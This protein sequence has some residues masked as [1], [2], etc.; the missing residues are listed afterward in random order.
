MPTAKRPRRAK[1]STPPTPR[2]CFPELSSRAY[3]HPADRAALA[4]LRKVK[5]VDLV[6]R[7]L[8]GLVGERSLRLLFLGSAV[9]VEADQF[10]RLHRVYRECAETL[11]VRPVPELYVT[12]TPLVNAGAVGVDQPFIVLNSALL[13][14]LDDDELRFVLGHELGHV[15]S[16]HVLYKTMLQLL[17]RVSLVLT[18]LP[19]GNLA[20]FSIISALNEWDRK[21]EYSADRAGL[22]ALQDPELCYRVSM[23]MAGGGQ[24][25]QMSVDAFVRQAEEYEQAGNILDGALKLLN[26]LGRS[27]PFH[28]LRLAEL[29]RW[30]ETGDYPRILA[31]TYPRRVDDPG[32]P[33]LDDL[34]ASADSY[35]ESFDNSRDPLVTAVRDVGTSVTTAATHLFDEL[36]RMMN[37][38]TPRK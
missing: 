20:L 19:L 38:G 24:V 10:A 29:K 23:K 1:R 35:K 8:M 13:D 22:L 33:V 11:D 31:G 15:L 21:S 14:L 2:V 9:R 3:E 32:Q 12:Q 7:K 26:L 27:H 37:E 5:G 6:L 28:V 18:G 25:D 4:A 36:R 30:A 16:G 17:L 34:K